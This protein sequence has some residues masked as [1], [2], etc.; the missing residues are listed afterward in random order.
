MVWRTRDVK[1]IVVEKFQYPHPGDKHLKL[2]LGT[3][4][5]EWAVSTH[6]TDNGGYIWTNY[7]H[8]DNVADAVKYF[9]ERCAQLLR[10]RAVQ[11]DMEASHAGILANEF[12]ERHAK[13]AKGE[14]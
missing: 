5:G 14:E 8:Q 3:I 2:C 11:C 13:L 1:I 4:R 12:V 7:F 9:Y 6:N 10:T